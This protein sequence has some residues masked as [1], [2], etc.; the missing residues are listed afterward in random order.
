MSSMRVQER[1]W[2]LSSGARFEQSQYEAR[3]VDPRAAAGNAIGTWMVYGFKGLRY[4][5]S[6]DYR[7]RVRA[8]WNDHPD[9]RAGGIRRMIL[10]AMLDGSVIA[11]VVWLI[12]A[13]H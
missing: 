6:R 3:V 5:V 10:G 9:R 1:S 12:A 8:F 11:F 2:T 7:S 13:R 4:V